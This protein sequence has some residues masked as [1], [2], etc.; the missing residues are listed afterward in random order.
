MRNAAASAVAFLFV[1]LPAAA[2]DIAA[3]E[4]K[5]AVCAACHG[6]AGNST[7]PEWPSL[8]QQPAQFISTA[9]FMFREGNRKND[10]MAPMAKPLSNAEMNDLAAYFAAQKAAP[11]RHKSKPEN[12]AAGPGLAKKFNCSQCH[13]P[14]LMG[15]QHIPRLAGQQYEYVLVQLKA[16]KAQTRADIDGNMTSAAMAL[17]PQDV[18][19]LADYVAGLPAE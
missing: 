18:E 1:S 12:V 15:Q 9:L 13:G 17:S 10:L 3:G 4:K 11:P 14:R 16:F 6:E 8:A 2:A 5:A 7:N 19:V